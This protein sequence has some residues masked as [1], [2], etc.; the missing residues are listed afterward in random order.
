MPG[1]GDSKQTTTQQSQTAP[2]E[3]AQPALKG[4]LGQLQGQLGNTGLTANENTALNTLT[5]NAA[6]AGQFAPA[7]KDYAT[8][9]LQGGGA[10]A[11]AGNIQAGYDR[12]VGQTNPLASNTN[13]DPRNTPGFGDVLDTLKSDITQSVNGQFAAAGRD[14]S[15]ANSQA[16]GRGLMQG[17]APVIQSQYNQN[18]QNQQGAARDLFGASNTNAGL[19]SGLQQQYLANQ[20]AGIGASG[21]ALDAQNNGANAVLA[22]EAQRRGIP[23]QSLGLLANIGVPIAGLGSQSSGTSTTNN[24]ASLVDTVGKWT[25]VGT[26]LFSS[27]LPS[28][29]KFISDRSAKTDIEQVGSLFDGTPVYR[30]RYKGEPRFQIGL[31]AQDVQQRTP[32]AVGKIG[33][34]LAVDYK[35]ATDKALEVA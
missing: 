11:Q 24:Q 14:F 23:L 13:Y 34:W 10:N 16:L 22:A 25:N 31:M 17:L 5:A 9:L 21:A 35:L 8:N 4:I 6:N 29:F 15:G 1:S 12:Y 7:I 18:V 26:N 2:W 3:A 30:Y 19:L 33:P 32:E 20:G 28:A 27:A